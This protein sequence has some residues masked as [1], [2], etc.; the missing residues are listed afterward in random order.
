VVLKRPIG[1]IANR[2]KGRPTKSC[3]TEERLLPSRIPKRQKLNAKYGLEALLKTR[4]MLVR[5]LEENQRLVRNKLGWKMNINVLKRI[6]EDLL[7]RERRSTKRN[8]QSMSELVLPS[9]IKLNEKILKCII[10]V[11]EDIQCCVQ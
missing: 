6:S 1:V 11:R 10:K 3:K 7:F 4:K 9:D 8:L 5:L 2:P